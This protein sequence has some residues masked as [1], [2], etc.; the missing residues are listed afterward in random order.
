MQLGEHVFP[1]SPMKNLLLPIALLALGLLPAS[2]LTA[3]VNN[4][5]TST[6]GDSRHH[7]SAASSQSR[8]GHASSSGR[9]GSST[10]GHTASSS[11][12]R[13]RA[14]SSQSY[15]RS[16]SSAG[17]RHGSRDYHGKR[18]SHRSHARYASAKRHTVS[19]ARRHSYGTYR[20]RR[21][22]VDGYYYRNP[23]G[24]R[25][26]VEGHYRRGWTLVS[27]RPRISVR[28]Y[29]SHAYEATL[30]RINAARYERTR[31]RIARR[32]VREHYLSSRQVRGILFLFRYETTRLEFAQYAYRYV[33]DPWNFYL[34]YDAF[35]YDRSI[36]EL[37]AY[38][39]HY[40]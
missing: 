14:E 33:A 23:Y 30:S 15:S 8:S 38:I 28:I 10:R 19:Y 32:A 16:H 27:P 9:R 25:V 5:R 34:T 4:R 7:S 2:G 40:D 36:D 35:R 24:K 20:R 39:R 18:S 12:S 11:S 13:S 1:L 21:V 26:Y 31:H 17:R 22:Y 3:Q 6:A 29:A 37:D